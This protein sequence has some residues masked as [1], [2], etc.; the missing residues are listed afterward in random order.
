MYS[1][2]LVL[3]RTRVISKEMSQ[4]RAELYAAL[5][6]THTG[7]VIR[8]SFGKYHQSSSKFTDSQIVLHWI[9][10]DPKPLKQ[11]A[12]N[13]VVEIL[14]FTDRQQWFCVKSKEM[15]ADL[16]TR[17]GATIKDVDQ[18]SSWIN[19][20][21]WMTKDSSIFPVQNASELNLSNAQVSEVQKESTINVQ[22]SLVLFTTVPEEVQERYEFSQYL[23]D[24]NLHSFRN[25]VRILA[26]VMRFCSRLQRRIKG[27]FLKQSCHE[28][29]DDE[30]STAENY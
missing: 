22:Q 10:N 15:I 17:R 25:V 8:R 11:W 27:E 2:Q 24:P 26:Y 3:S 21:S 23:I 5:V 20:F 7:E 6:N 4:P 1:C 28:L 12:R 18:S 19:G 14:R 16:G 9:N 30:I 13:R 29:T